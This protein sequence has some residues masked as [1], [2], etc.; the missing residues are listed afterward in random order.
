MTC[1]SL[2][3][4]RLSRLLGD[5]S[6][7]LHGSTGEVLISQNEKQ[8]LIPASVVKIPLSQVA[9]TVLG[10]AFRFETHFYKNSEGDLLI[11]GLGDP[12]LISE[13][14]ATIASV[15][16]QQGLK[17]IRRIVMDDSAFEANPDLPLELGAD[18]PYAARVSA[19]A[20]NFNTV[21]FA[22]STEGE[23]MSGESQ[24]PLT[25]IA[26]E[27]GS[28]L[29]KGE[30]TRINLGED[31]VAGLTQAQ[32]LFAAFFSAEGIQVSDSS[33]YRERVSE[34]WDLLYQH[35]SSMALSEILRGML[36]YSNNFIANQLFLVLGAQEYG[37]P[38]TVE[39]AQSVLQEHLTNLYGDGFGTESEH[40]LMIEGSGLA[41]EQLTTGA[42][43]MQILENFRPFAELL[44]QINGVYRKSGT[45][46]GIY[47]YAGYIPRPDGLHPFVILTNQS[48]NNRDEILQILRQN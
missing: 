43:M 15:L 46:T 20:V 18:D 29:R 6:V 30:S 13:E 3:Q 37:Y 47:N 41:R 17:Q 10:E 14:I 39:S 1:P 19:L 27:L 9:L 38:A 16:S 35:R 2:A 21:N 5:G 25:S 26:R 36:R 7:V 12:F 40:L 32:Q 48:E 11:R 24:T 8:T 31:A 44:P 4:D 33:F 34:S 23:L 45:L 42:G 22:W 28:Q